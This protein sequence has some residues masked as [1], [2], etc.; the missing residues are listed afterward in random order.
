MKNLFLII[1]GLLLSVNAMA[2]DSDWKLCKGDAILFDR[3]ASIVVNAFEHRVS[4]G[5]A[6]DITLIYGGHILKGS[7]S[8]SES[9]SGTVLLKGI[10]SNFKG[11]V[12][13]DYGRGLMTLVGRLELNRSA[14]DLKATLECETL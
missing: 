4:K 7:Y 11:N 6:A 10:G 1:A 3:D 12:A 2:L 13:I 5:R 14:S 8:T 9:T